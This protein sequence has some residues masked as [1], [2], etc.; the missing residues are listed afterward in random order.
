VLGDLDGDGH[1]DAA[2]FDPSLGG[3]AV[4]LQNEAGLLGRRL[5]PVGAVAVDSLPGQTLGAFLLAD[6]DGDGADEIVNAE[7]L[8][9]ADLGNVLQTAVVAIAPVL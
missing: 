5:R 3:R 9:D 1:V 2:L 8:F 6:L 4:V 7:Y